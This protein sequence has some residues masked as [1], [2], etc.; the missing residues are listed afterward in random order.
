MTLLIRSGCPDDF[1]CLSFPQSISSQYDGDQKRKDFLDSL[2]SYLEKEG[3]SRAWLC[4]METGLVCVDNLSSV[5]CTCN[6]C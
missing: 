1:V 2:F 5:K 6:M 3:Q 4:G